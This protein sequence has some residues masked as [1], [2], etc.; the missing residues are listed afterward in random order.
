MLIIS[1]GERKENKKIF[2]YFYKNKE[3]IESTFGS[4]LDW[5]RLDDKKMSRI[6]SRLHGVSIFN[7]EDWEDMMKFL[8]DSMIK[9]EYV[10]R[11]Y[12]DNYSKKI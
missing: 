12:I 8:T 11:K 5:E 10:L 3:N 1:G 9:F 7:R 4:K 2:D 6:A